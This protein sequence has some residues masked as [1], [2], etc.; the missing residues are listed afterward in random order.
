M[1]DHGGAFPE[2]SEGLRT[3]PGVGDYP[4]AAIAAIALGEAVAV[5]D[6]NVER[7]APRGRDHLRMAVG[8]GD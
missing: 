5:V 3:L 6:G 4:S 1:A 2:S 8:K 7:V